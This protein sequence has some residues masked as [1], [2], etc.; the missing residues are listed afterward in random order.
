LHLALFRHQDPPMT[1]DNGQSLTR[2][3]RRLLR[4]IFNGLA[5]PI[6]ADGKSFL[7]YKDASRHLLSLAPEA[8]DAV[9]AELKD[10]G[11]ASPQ[12]GKGVTEG[13]GD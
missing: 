6:V 3:Q 2:P 1:D 11:Q 12:A 5:I 13:P 7:T 8:R 9:Y 10:Q 4:R